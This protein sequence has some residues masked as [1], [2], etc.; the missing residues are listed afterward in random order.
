MTNLFNQTAD[1]TANNLQA[2]S[3]NYATSFMHNIG[4]TN[5]TAEDLLALY[6]NNDNMDAALNSH[7]PLASADH[8]WTTA[9]SEEELTKMLKS[10]Q[11]K[12]SRLK[13]KDM[14]QANFMSSVEAA[15]AER[16]LRLALGKEKNVQTG[17][18]RLDLNELTEEQAQFF[19]DNQQALGKAIRNVQSRKSQALSKGM[20]ATDDMF[21]ALCE[22]E[23]KLKELRVS[24][25]RVTT[26]EVY[27]L[28]PEQ[29]E[30]INAAS[31]VETLLVD[32]DIDK[33]KVADCR[34]LLHAI[35]QSLETE[36]K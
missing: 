10:Q 6:T 19:T 11:S 23:A 3:H 34:A 5:P 27:K 4:N 15:A 29:E 14:T 18:V 28:T 22:Y 32:V 7:S 1:N 25:A 36:V 35:A 16:I 2:D 13:S 33:L 20:E 31:A 24:T 30:R 9:F 12:R 21:V 26:V 8:N 17:V